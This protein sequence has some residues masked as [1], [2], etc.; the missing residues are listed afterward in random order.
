MT[1]DPI[2]RRILCALRFVDAAT[3]GT[4]SSTLRVSAEGAKIV[5]NLSNLYVI[6]EHRGATS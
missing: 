2:D 3:R 5:R 1:R 6:T 4:V